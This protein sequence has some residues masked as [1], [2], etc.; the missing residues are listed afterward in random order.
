MAEAR[1][2]DIENTIYRQKAQKR[3]EEWMAK[4]KRDAFIQIK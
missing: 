1:F 3:Y 4:L 2:D